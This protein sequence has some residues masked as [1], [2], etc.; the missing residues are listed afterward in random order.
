[1]ICYKIGTGK[2]KG[3]D[4]IDDILSFGGYCIFDILYRGN[5]RSRVSFDTYY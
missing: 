2:K 1:M 3:V 5:Q 4:K